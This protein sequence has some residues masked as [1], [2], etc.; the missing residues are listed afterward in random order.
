MMAEDQDLGGLDSPGAPA[1]Q[2]Q[3]DAEE[4]ASSGLASITAAAQQRLAQAAGSSLAEIV[5]LP[6]CVLA[7]C[8]AAG[9]CCGLCD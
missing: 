9:T 6:G 3:Q 4:D 5:L 7:A 8:W 1:V 2:A